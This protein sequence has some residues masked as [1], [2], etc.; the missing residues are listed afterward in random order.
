MI[1]CQGCKIGEKKYIHIAKTWPKIS[2]YIPTNGF[3]LQISIYHPSLF[4]FIYRTHNKRYVQNAKRRD[5]PEN[6]DADSKI[7]QSA[8]GQMADGGPSEVRWLDDNLHGVIKS[9]KR[10]QPYIPTPLNSDT[11]IFRQIHIRYNTG[12]VPT[13]LCS[14]NSIID[15][16]RD[17]RNIGVSEHRGVGI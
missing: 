1:S 10:L 11:P 14:D 8:G 12:S 3:N 7:R 16:Y 9:F 6:S 4:H 2:R 5:N 17:C 15:E 13:P